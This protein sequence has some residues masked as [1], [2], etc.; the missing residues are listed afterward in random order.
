M[1]DTYITASLHFASATRKSGPSSTLIPAGL[2]SSQPKWQQI[3]TDRAWVPQARQ[4]ILIF[5]LHTSLPRKK[6]INKNG[7]LKQLLPFG[8][9]PVRI[10]GALH[11][12]ARGS[13]FAGCPQLWL[14]GSE[15]PAQAS[16]CDSWLGF[17]VQV[18]EGKRR[19]NMP[20]RL[21]IPF[22]VSLL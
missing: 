18:G 11:W 17:F 22:S 5:N 7:L 19:E 2:C 10:F 13:R 14:Q 12:A 16:E 21:G 9:L 6:N 15:E 3:H 4:V 20:R 1:E 8:G